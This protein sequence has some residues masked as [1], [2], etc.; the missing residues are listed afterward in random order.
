[1]AKLVQKV[2]FILISRYLYNFLS[3]FRKLWYHMQGMYVGHNTYLPSIKI[4]WPHQVVIG[5][6]CSLEQG[7]YFKFD[8]IWKQGP[9]IIIKNNVFIG[10][11]CE[12]NIRKEIVIGDNSLIASGC[13]FIDHDHGTS[14]SSPMH[15]Q[16]GPEKA[17][18]IGNDVWLGC[19]V[20]VLKGVEIADGVIV[21]AGA[22]VTKDIP[23]YE[24]W[25]GIPAKKISQRN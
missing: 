11:G 23:P 13:K 22:V 3:W 2:F 21:A 1:M 12:F 19:N 5:D 9:S 25:A 17:I 7:I 24:I 6:N 20:V 18:L 10:A 16:Q 4:T 8:G 15:K 14:L